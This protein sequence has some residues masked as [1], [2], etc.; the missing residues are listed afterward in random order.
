MNPIS[1]FIVFMHLVL[2]PPVFKMLQYVR[3][4]EIFKRNTPP[5]IIIL[6]YILLTIAITQLVLGYFFTLFTAFE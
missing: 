6:M 4:D 3:L 2:L 5:N 1:L